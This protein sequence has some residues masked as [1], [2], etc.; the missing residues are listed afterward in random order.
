MLLEMLRSR[1]VHSLGGNRLKPDGK[2]QP[3]VVDS[4][5]ETF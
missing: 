2:A 4:D 1:V 3:L 5:W